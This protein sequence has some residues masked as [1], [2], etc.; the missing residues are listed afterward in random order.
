M[1]FNP[2]LRRWRVTA[3]HLTRSKP[4][5]LPGNLSRVHFL[6]KLEH[7]ADGTHGA[8]LSIQAC[9]LPNAVDRLDA[10]TVRSHEICQTEFAEPG[11]GP[12]QSCVVQTEQVES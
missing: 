10:G 1:R 9:Q 7:A 2:L 5:D 12:F 8:G 6:P 3:D 11:S 4:P